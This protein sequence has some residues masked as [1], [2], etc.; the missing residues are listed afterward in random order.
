[1]T[2]EFEKSKAHVRLL[3]KAV[4]AGSR[5]RVMSPGVHDVIERIGK[6]V[7][8]AEIV[9]ANGKVNDIVFNPRGSRLGPVVP[10]ILAGQTHIAIVEWIQLFCHAAANS[11]IAREKINNNH[12]HGADCTTT[13]C[14]IMIAGSIA[15]FTR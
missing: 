12:C 5:F 4:R 11:R 9:D 8:D 1:V 10:S 6:T 3:I 13:D 15:F 2:I 14:I 7:V